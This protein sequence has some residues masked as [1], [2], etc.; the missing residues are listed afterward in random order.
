M[1]IVVTALSQTLKKFLFKYKRDVCFHGVKK[2]VTYISCTEF[3]V[4]HNFFEPKLQDYLYYYNY[5]Y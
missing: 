2:T 4:L 3:P 5:Y 1:D